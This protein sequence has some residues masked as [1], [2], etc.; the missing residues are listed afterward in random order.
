MAWRFYSE[1]PTLC[2]SGTD[3]RRRLHAIVGR[4]FEALL[5]GIAFVPRSRG[6]VTLPGKTWVKM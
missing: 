6:V 4:L 2:I 1:R 3:L 5:V